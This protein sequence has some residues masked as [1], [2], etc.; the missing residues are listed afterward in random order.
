MSHHPSR[1]AQLSA[2]SATQPDPWGRMVQMDFGLH[3]V[4]RQEGGERQLGR[5]EG[6]SGARL[7]GA[8]SRRVEH[9]GR[10]LPRRYPQQTDVA[11]TEVRARGRPLECKPSH[12]WL[13]REQPLFRSRRPSREHASLRVRT[14]GSP[15]CALPVALPARVSRAPCPSIVG[16][17]RWNS[18]LE[19]E[20]PTVP[21]F[22]SI[23]SGPSA[24]R[25]PFRGHA[26]SLPDT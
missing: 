1:R 13:G 11:R 20:V 6:A 25:A 2:C 10:G 12:R 7:Q 24:V 4:K 9:L 26:G 3:R 19:E 22:Q 21:A 15:G 23:P 5:V 17:Q 14:G 18:T 16:A 8:I